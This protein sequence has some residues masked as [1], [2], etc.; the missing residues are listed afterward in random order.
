MGN[1]DFSRIGRHIGRAVR[2][3]ARSG[4]FE[5]IGRTIGDGVQ[6]FADSVSHAFGTA[7]T[8]HR[9]QYPP[10][11]A[12]PQNPADG[13]QNPPP[14]AGY[15]NPGSV[16]T[17]Q[18]SPFRNRMPGTVAGL[19]C[20]IVGF[21]MGS[22]FLIADICVL[23]AAF[24]Q[25]LSSASFVVTAS[26]LFPLTA[27][28]LGVGIYGVARRRRAC[29]FARYRDAL[30][31]ASFGKVSA[32]AEAA[33]ESEEKT[34]RDLRKMITSGACPHG[35]LDAAGTCFMVDDST[36]ADYLEAEHAYQARQQAARAEEE[37]KQ[38]D[39]KQAEMESVKQ[40]GLEY[41]RQIREANDALPGKEISDKLDRLESVAARI[42]HCVEE[43]PEKLPEIRRFMRYYMPTTLKLV[44]AYREFA[45]QPVE[46][47]N[48]AGAKAEIEHALDTVNAAFENLLDSLFADDA[49]DIST[50]I[51]TLETML[52]QEGLTGSDFK[53][54]DGSEK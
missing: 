10:Y 3:A 52:K 35:H 21:S 16:P 9:Q 39:P 46:G 47:E 42:F 2:R 44:K 13:Q 19:V 28:S 37:K 43:H 4:N 50:D 17:E 49:L 7:D 22:M 30:D 25:S 27:A 54:P 32:L 8:Q 14:Q 5:E 31:G 29:R 45:L 33:G 15:R 12:A 34:K 53:Q 18:F 36:Y 11:T 20:A 38:A 40:E 51:S 6:E 26:V 23:A 41:L 1:R 24:V 48:I